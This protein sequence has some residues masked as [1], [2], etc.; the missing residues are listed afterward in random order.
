MPSEKDSKPKSAHWVLTRGLL[1]GENEYR[2]FLLHCHTSVQEQWCGLTPA[3][4]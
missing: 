4:S 1:C 2:L 3:S